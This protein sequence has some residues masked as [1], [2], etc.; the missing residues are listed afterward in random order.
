MTRVDLIRHLTDG[1]L[2]RL[3]SR[4]FLKSKC[5]N[6]EL[7]L[8]VSSDNGTTVTSYYFDLARTMCLENFTDIRVA[9]LKDFIDWSNT[10]NQGNLSVKWDYLRQG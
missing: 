7:V 9:N 2:I 3:D 6:S 1:K 4:Y 5:G 8:F 10:F